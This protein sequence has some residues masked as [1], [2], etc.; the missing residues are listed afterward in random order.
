MEDVDAGGDAAIG[1]E[2]GCTHGG[3]DCLV[4]DVTKNVWWQWCLCPTSRCFFPSSVKRVYQHPVDQITRVPTP[5]A[6]TH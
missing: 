2:G 3:R 1:Q 5:R 6:R 4:W